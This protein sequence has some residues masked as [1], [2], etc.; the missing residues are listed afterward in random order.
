MSRQTIFLF[1]AAFF[2]ATLC[3]SIA[4]AGNIKKTETVDGLRVELNVL[5]AEPFFTASEVEAGHVTKGMLI[6]GGA[7]PLALK[8]QPRPNHHMV[9]HVFDAKSGRALTDAYVRME[10]QSL[11]DQGKPVGRAEE[12]PVVVME[13]IGKGPQ[14]THYGNNV[15][16]HSGRYVVTVDVNGRKLKFPIAL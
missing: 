2:T 3:V 10:Y 7:K 6:M 9:V 16:I 11:N 1:M 13:E 14:S 4:E 15:V 5:P 12:V 8:A